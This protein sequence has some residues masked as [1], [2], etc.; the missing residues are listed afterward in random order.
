V[1]ATVLIPEPE[2]DNNQLAIIPEVIPG[3]LQ[4]LRPDTPESV[5]LTLAYEQAQ[6]D[7]NDVLYAVMRQVGERSS[8]NPWDRARLELLRISSLE[9]NW[10]GEN[11][12]PVMEET[13]R[14][15][16]VLIETAALLGDSAR[17][18]DQ[19]VPKIFPS[20]NGSI[21]FKFVRAD[22][23]LKCIVN[24]GT[25]EVLRWQPLEAFEAENLWEVPVS[26]VPE[27]IDWLLR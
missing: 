10:D 9:L 5:P 1:A 3:S 21:T 11:A 20:A 12:A 18:L 8:V 19:A 25:V 4:E 13:M 14:T 6:P 15:A 17:T 23:E 26:D 7:P 2:I 22:K 27:H 24:E 16:T